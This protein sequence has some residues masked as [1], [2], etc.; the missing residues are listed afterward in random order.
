MPLS[1]KLGLPIAAHQAT[2]DRL[3][4][5][6]RI[7][8]ILSDDEPLAY[9]PRGWR[10]LHL[11]GHT[12]GHLCFIE[13]GSGAVAAGDLVAGGSTVVIDPPEGDMHDYLR[14]LDR[15]LALSPRTIYPAH[16]QVVPAGA[17]LLR[18]YLAHRL[19]REGKV[20]AALAAHAPRGP[21]LPEELV[22]GAYPEISPELYPL[23]ERSLIAHLLKLVKDGRANEAG[24]RFSAR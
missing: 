8:R 20:A 9:G 6:V 23:A 14:S 7:D 3:R 15:L 11:P 4:G 13:G 10:A 19:E 1:A 5:E 21:A 24:G 18:G 22:P 16:G 17:E 12:Q 2:A